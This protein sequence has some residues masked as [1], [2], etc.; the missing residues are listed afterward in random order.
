MTAPLE[1]VGSPSD[2]SPEGNLDV[3]IGPFETDEIGK[4]RFFLW[5]GLTGDP[6]AAAPAVR[7]IAGSNVLL[8]RSASSAI[9]SP[10]VSTAPYPGPTPWA[11]H[12]YYPLSV[13]EVRALGGRGPLQV[14]LAFA[15]TTWRRLE[16]WSA[17][18]TSF[19]PFVQR[20]LTGP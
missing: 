10:P 9:P 13:E 1:Y 16:A 20:V 8:E 4:R 3:A 12:Y 6:A 2:T 7:L 11:R 19:D 17:K 5:L 18:A 15:G 14:E